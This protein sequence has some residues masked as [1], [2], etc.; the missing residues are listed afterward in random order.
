MFAIARAVLGMRFLIGVDIGTQGSKGALISESG[1]ILASC[2]I[3]QDV[4]NPHPGWAEHD[5]DR[6]WW[7]GFVGVVR[8]LLLQSEVDPR[9]IAGVGVSGLMPVMLPVDAD[10]R[11]LRPAILF[12]NNPAHTEMVRMN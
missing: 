3:E 11:P 9:Q 7:G 1:Q 12:S 10:G 8:R 4:S 5:A 2:S 6:A